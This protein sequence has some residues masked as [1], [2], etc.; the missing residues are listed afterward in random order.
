MLV[1]LPRFLVGYFFGIVNLDI[2]ETRMRKNISSHGGFRFIILTYDFGISGRNSLP[3]HIWIL[4]FLTVDHSRFH[5][6]AGRF[7]KGKVIVI[8]SVCFEFVSYSTDQFVVMLS[9]Y[10]GCLILVMLKLIIYRWSC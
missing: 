3:N 1:F 9:N 7:R 6:N 4:I 5:L 8:L 2:V 10:T